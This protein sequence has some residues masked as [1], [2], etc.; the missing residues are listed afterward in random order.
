[1]PQ[2]TVR[3]GDAVSRGHQHVAAPPR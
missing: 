2:V 1:L 3:V